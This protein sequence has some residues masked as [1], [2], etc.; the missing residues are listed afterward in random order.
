MTLSVSEDAPT[1]GV[2]MHLRKKAGR[3]ANL[4]RALRDDPAP[5]CV[6]ISHTRWATHGPANDRNAHPHVSAGGT[7][8][9]VHNGVIENYAALK[10]QLQSEGVE[11][12]SDTDTEVIAQLIGRELDAR[13]DGNEDADVPVSVFVDVLSKCLRMLKGTYGLGVIS[14]R[15][16]GVILGARLGSPLVVGI[17]ENEHFLASDPAALIGKADKV[18]YMQDNQ[19][20]GNRSA[21]SVLTCSQVSSQMEAWRG[22][23][24][25]LSSPFFWRTWVPTSSRF[26]TH[27]GP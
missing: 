7:V 25:R 14:S 24:S 3:I 15:F 11:F 4:A 19:L 16:P 5:G 9:V 8:A 17:G 2:R 6:G 1:R 23:W 20:A 27:S 22:N 26:A 21:G 18:V 13:L 10:K 12:A